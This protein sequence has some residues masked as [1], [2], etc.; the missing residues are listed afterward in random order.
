[1]AS[2]GLVRRTVGALTLALLL[3][4]SPATPSLSAWADE[5]T[6][7]PSPAPSEV[8][9]ENQT[10]EH[11]V[12]LLMDQYV[13]PVDSATLLN[14]GWTRLQNDATRA[15]APA[16]GDPPAFTGD[17][18]G[19][20]GAL[21]DALTAYIDQMPSL[22]DGFVPAYSLVRGMVDLLNEGHTYFLDPGAYQD[23]QQWTAGQ[24]HYV[25]I[26]VGLST[27]GAQP[28]IVE[29]YENTPAAQAGLR[30]GDV[31]LQID[32]R[33]VDGLASNEVTSLMR[34]PADS[35]VDLLVQ[36][37]G[38]DDPLSFTL[39]RVDI[40]L[41]FVDQRVVG[42]DVGYVLLRG[43]PEPSVI[44]TVEQDFDTFQQ[45]GVHGLILDLRGNGG[46]RI[47]LGRRLLGDFIPSGTP[48][49]RQIDRDGRAQTDRSR[50]SVRFTTPLVVLVDGGTASMAELFASAI[51]EDGAGK[52][53]GSLT[54]G[55]VAGSEVFPLGDGSGLQVTVFD[56]HAAD[57]KVLNG[58]GVAPDQTVDP[59]PTAVASGDDPTLDRA[60]EI[61]H[62]ESTGTEPSPAPAG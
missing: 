31:I 29:V 49:F 2:L 47:D 1:M 51:E 12:S 33:S 57:D 59:D 14:A 46:G 44:D 50:G 26:G 27:R 38:E 54:A 23:Y 24:R 19:D 58:V 53:V 20:L 18:V 25:G 62:A 17:R 40:N 52:V 32:G 9:T 16:P 35:Q 8:A 15:G 6:P 48:L 55:S 30:V 37:V 41:A 43:F 56:I 10:V 22:P 28:S 11:A 45:Q 39:T 42:D 21:H 4:V 7:T 61:L 60:V 36:R 13:H 34:G 3:L 5:S